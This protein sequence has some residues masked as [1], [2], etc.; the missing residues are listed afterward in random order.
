MRYKISNTYSMLRLL[1]DV[2]EDY[3]VRVTENVEFLG[4][5]FVRMDGTDD[6]CLCVLEL[7]VSS[8]LLPLFLILV[9]FCHT[10]KFLSSLL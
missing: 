4:C 8:E 9:F 10:L 2:V 3:F 7:G 6:T 1:W 5:L